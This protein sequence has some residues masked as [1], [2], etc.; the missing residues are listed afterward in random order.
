MLQQIA[1][2]Y[3]CVCVQVYLKVEIIYICNFDRCLQILSYTAI[4][5][6]TNNIWEHSFLYTCFNFLNLYHSVEGEKGG[7]SNMLLTFISLIMIENIFMFKNYLYFHFEELLVYILAHFFRDFF[8]KD[9]EICYITY[10][11]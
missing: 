1:L 4:H 2:Y 10:D 5:I 7:V 9:L 11:Y 8:G 3:S 6:S